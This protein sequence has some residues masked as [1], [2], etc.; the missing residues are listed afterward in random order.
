LACT[1]PVGLLGNPDH[2]TSQLTRGVVADLPSTSIDRRAQNSADDAMLATSGRVSGPVVRSRNSARLAG[3][4]AWSLERRLPVLIS[5]L[6]ACV[7]GGLSLAAYRE[8][9]GTAIT[10]ASERLE[11]VG[12]ELI[13][14]S[15]RSTA[16]QWDVLHG[17]ASDSLLTRVLTSSDR[18]PEDA[19]SIATRV[20][21]ARQPSDSVLL[22]VRVGDL[23]G[24]SRFVSSEWKAPDSATLVSTLGTMARTGKE[25]R[26]P[27]YAVDGQVHEWTV[28]PIRADGRLIGSLAELRRVGDASSADAAIRGLIDDDARMLYTSRG[29]TLWVTTR[30]APVSEP[31]ERPSV[32]NHTVRVASDSGNQLVAM[33][34]V[35]ASPWLV[36]LMQSESSVLRR[37]QDFLRR[38]LGAGL[39]VL[40]IAAAGAWLLSRHV[41]RPLRDVTD[42]AAALAHGDYARRVS[43]AGGGREVAS[44]SGT[45]NAMAEAIGDAHT[46][47]AERNLELQR[48][49][50][51]KAQFLAMMSHELRTPLNAIGGF[52]EL[53]ELGLRGPV[54]PQQV[55]DLGRIRRNKDVLLSIITDILDFTRADAG[56][57]SVEL[58][59]IAIAP[60]L[61]DVV[62]AV[63]GQMETKGVR[64]VVEPIP[65]DA[66]VRGD[67]ER[68]QQVLLNL[69]SNAMKFTE[70][71]GEVVVATTVA[72]A[73]V[74]VDVRDTGPGI[75]AEQLDAIFEP[76]VQVDASLTRRAG[77]TGLGLAIAR[78][79]AAAMGGTVTVQSAVGEGS[80]FSLTLPHA[81]RRGL[82]PPHGM[83]HAAGQKV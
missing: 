76:F 72:D 24:A 26:S 55:Q 41:T 44:L 31:F 79:L 65:A 42:A 70:H 16:A 59:T 21:A 7:V 83:M 43:V 54:T 12:R 52:T 45:F 77:G 15:V 39:V 47:L 19:A 20:A 74:R 5:L 60:L 53:I 33:F 13:L 50:A 51:A 63:S 4:E 64:L 25:Q 30:G 58:S 71:G 46:T 11:R 6:V 2:R 28:V 48:A 3:A 37:P 18:R 40:A 56:V 9:R 34:E 23:A 38:L 35:P 61:I 22:A 80:T 66:I 81:E 49:N 62:E 78:Q 14:A 27:F 36:V 57:L 75:G 68:M 1:C 32:V 17:L 82:T 29:S 8:V 10:R 69:L 67:R 73:L